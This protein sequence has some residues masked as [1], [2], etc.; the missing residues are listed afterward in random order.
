MAARKTDPAAAPGVG[1]TV[2]FTRVYDVP[3]ALVY[4]AWTDPKELAKWWGPKGFTNPVCEL[5]ARPGGAIRIDMTAPDGTVYLM[6]GTVR[7]VAPPERFVFAATAHDEKRRPIA[8]VLNSATFSER[9]GKTTMEIRSTVL[10]ATPEAASSLAGMRQGW[11][12]SLVRLAEH[13]ATT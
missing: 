1:E 10:S 7:E 12:Q 2:V 6:T 13:V 4:R 11:T 5:D 9:G 3:R 8:E